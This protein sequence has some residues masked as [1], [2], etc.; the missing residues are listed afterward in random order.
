LLRLLP[1]KTRLRMRVMLCCA[2]LGGVVGVCLAFVS[3][4]IAERYERVLINDEMSAEIDAQIAHL[5]KNPDEPLPN[6]EWKTLYIDR[7]GQPPTSPP[8]LRSLAPGLHEIGDA[9]S[10][11]FAGVRQT[12]IG[13]VTMV[14]SLPNSPARERRFLEELLA[15]ILFGIGLGA[16]LGRVLAGSMLAPVLRLSDQVEHADPSTALRG[17]AEDHQADEVG[18]L[19]NAF[20]HYH[21]RVQAAIEREVLFSA[22]ASHELRTPLTVLQ[23]ALDLLRDS[24]A[25]NAAGRRRVERIRRSAAEIGTLLDALLLVAR[26]DEGTEPPVPVEIG[27]VLA[28]VIAEFHEELDAMRIALGVRCPPATTVLAPPGLLRVVLRLLFR[29]IAS[30]AWGDALRIDADATGFVLATAA[31]LPESTPAAAPSGEAGDGA[32]ADAVAAPAVPRREGI[33]RRSD[34]SGGLGMLRRLCERYG[35]SLVHAR[36]P[37]QPVLLTVRLPARADERADN[38]RDSAV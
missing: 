32:A 38:A 28:S 4:H 30:G 36:D 25:S 2:A 14:A 33:T 16:L 19:A 7:P 17:I 37:G 29:S 12:P 9:D 8:A 22:D 18:T 23:G 1:R 24:Q 3:E 11:R 5:G 31:A 6:S 34:E 13:R 27:P 10:D 21:A 15:M 20:I 26:A 35:W